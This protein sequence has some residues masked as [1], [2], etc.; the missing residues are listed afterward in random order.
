MSVDVRLC[1][2]SLASNTPSPP[3]PKSIKAEL[4]IILKRLT[5]PLDE[6]IA[7]GRAAPSASS[8][9][10]LPSLSYFPPTPEALLIMSGMAPG[11]GGGKSQAAAGAT[12]PPAP[13]PPSSSQQQPQAAVAEKA[14][15][16][17]ESQ[18]QEE[19]KE[20]GKWVL[21]M[22]SRDRGAGGGGARLFFPT[23][24][25]VPEMEEAF[26]EE[27]LGLTRAHLLPLLEGGIGE[28]DA[29]SLAVEWRPA[30]SYRRAVLRLTGG[31]PTVVVGVDG[32]EEEASEIRRDPPDAFD[33]LVKAL[34]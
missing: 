3:L 27:V 28:V 24:L 18:E 13:P 4:L 26:R 14:T 9:A 10:P 32:G 11:G 2:H 17:K 8:A 29:G 33:V 34:V 22:L 12:A 31:L 23:R 15:A 16:T 1:H 5:V 30:L 7:R 20:K 19:E 25:A 6:V 21:V